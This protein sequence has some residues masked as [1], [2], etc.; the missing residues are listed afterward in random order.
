VRCTPG[1]YKLLYA[2]GM[3]FQRELVTLRHITDSAKSRLH[4]EATA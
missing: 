1:A 2:F 4:R 3:V